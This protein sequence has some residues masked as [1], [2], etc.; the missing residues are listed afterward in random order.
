MVA[1]SI[2]SAINRSILL[3]PTASDAL[4]RPL[5]LLAD[6]VPLRVAWRETGF[7]PSGVIFSFASTYSIQWERSPSA[8]SL[9]AGKHREWVVER[10]IN[11]P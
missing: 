5:S 6:P 4:R 2:E 11:S 1:D 7:Q 8:E 3:K 10:E 9:G